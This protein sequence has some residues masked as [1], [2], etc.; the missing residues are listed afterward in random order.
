M[1]PSPT[2]CLTAARAISIR[3]ATPMARALTP[4]I[5]PV[6]CLR[7]MAHAFGS[8]QFPGAARGRQQGG[9]DL[10]HVAQQITSYTLYYDSGTGTVDYGTVFGLVVSSSPTS[11]TTA[12]L[13]STAA[14]K[15]G[16]RATNRC[17]VTEAN[18]DVVAI[19]ASTSTLSTVRASIYSPVNG[20]DLAGGAEDSVGVRPDSD[21]AGR[22]RPSQCQACALPVPRRQQT[23]WTDIPSNDSNRPNPA[24]VLTADGLPPWLGTSVL[25]PC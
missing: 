15:F 13:N 9:A 21:G 24:T 20:A 22:F 1:C 2:F 11:L 12:V 17:G 8:W 7:P 18:T 14:Y 16:I 5:P 23:F 4:L 25:R 3:F 6:R 10:E 19:T